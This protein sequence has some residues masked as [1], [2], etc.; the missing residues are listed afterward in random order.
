MVVTA[1]LAYYIFEF[2][3]VSSET[4]ID[5]MAIEIK[6]VSVLF[7]ITVYSIVLQLKFPYDSKWHSI[8][9]HLKRAT[10][11]DSWSFFS[12]NST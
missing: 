6:H 2:N 12:G 4:P 11:M 8:L 5:R 3:F 1:A 9:V 10:P 7:T